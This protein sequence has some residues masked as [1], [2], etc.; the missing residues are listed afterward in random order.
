L[1]TTDKFGLLKLFQ[2]LISLQLLQLVYFLLLP[3]LLFLLAL[4][5]LLALISALII[6]ATHRILNLTLMSCYKGS[7]ALFKAEVVLLFEILHFLISS[8]VLIVN[9]LLSLALALRIPR[10]VLP[11]L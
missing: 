1:S 8:H 10:F 6:F 11:A 5:L 9:L 4:Y 7:I 3:S 2:N